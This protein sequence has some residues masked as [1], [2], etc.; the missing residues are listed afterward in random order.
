MTADVVLRR[1]GGLL[2]GIL[3]CLAAGCGSSGGAGLTI[4]E[5]TAKDSLVT[6]LDQWKSGGQPADLKNQ[7]PSII[8]R[9]F[10]WEAGSTLVS[11][12]LVSDELNDGANLH[13]LVDLT[14]RSADGKETETRARYIVGTEPTITVFRSDEELFVED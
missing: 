8:A 11:Y 13:T 14:L 9:D 2:C 1:T 7:S 5:S 3:I 6:V 12:E 4:D 10:D